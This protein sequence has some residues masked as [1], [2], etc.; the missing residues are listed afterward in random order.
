MNRII[1]FITLSIISLGAW[2][3]TLETSNDFLQSVNLGTRLKNIFQE[4][5][6]D[7]EKGNITA[8]LNDSFT[9][10]MTKE[11][12][13]KDFMGVA[14]KEN[15]FAGWGATVV[16]LSDFSSLEQKRTI[17]AFSPQYQLNIDGQDI[18][19]FS[20]YTLKA[21]DVEERLDEEDFKMLVTLLN[22]AEQMAANNPVVNTSFVF[23]N[24]E[25]LLDSLPYPKSPKLD[26]WTHGYKNLLLLQK[27]L[28]PIIDAVSNTLIENLNDALAANEPN[29]PCYLDKKLSEKIDHYGRYKPFAKEMK[30]YRENP[31][32]AGNYIDSTVVIW[33]KLDDLE[34]ISINKGVAE[35]KMTERTIYMAEDD[36][37]KVMPTWM[38]YVLLK[39]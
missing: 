13:E 28:E 1:A 18:G 2:A 21:S 35:L 5:H 25:I 15:M 7:F 23:E 29:L 38:V 32:M 34:E 26:E 39:D 4:I 9:S 8:Y 33:P 14:D 37:R 6:K 27:D 24:G 30:T 16:P 10:I 22:L 11:R 12:Y 17:I 19:T 20:H 3:Q 36:L 31:R